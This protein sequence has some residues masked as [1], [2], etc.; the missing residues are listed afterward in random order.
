MS[1]ITQWLTIWK[2]LEML[3]SRKRNFN[4]SRTRNKV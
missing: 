1:L 4:K 3:A 2:G